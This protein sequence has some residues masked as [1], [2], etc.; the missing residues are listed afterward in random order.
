MGFGPVLLST[1][2]HNVIRIDRNSNFR[3]KRILKGT[4]ATQIFFEVLLLWC[5]TAQCV[6]LVKVILF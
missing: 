1:S 4:I 2:P 6:I 3:I 5:C